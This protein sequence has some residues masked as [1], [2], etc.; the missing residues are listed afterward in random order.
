MNPR[1]HSQQMDSHL[2]FRMSFKDKKIVETAA[3]LK[4]FKLNTYA[5]QKLIEIAKKDIDSMS[6][7]NHLI[8]SE[9]DWNEFIKIME[10]PVPINPNLLKAIQE[11]NDIDP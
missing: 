3:K 11:F 1:N 8:L 7:S 2:N 4:G 5:R 9:A 10:S 6:Q